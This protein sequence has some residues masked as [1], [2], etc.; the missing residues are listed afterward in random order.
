MDFLDFSIRRIF[1]FRIGLK[2][3]FGSKYLSLTILD[4]VLKIVVEK[5]VYLLNNMPVYHNFK[6]KIFPPK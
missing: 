6:H 2:I 4:P 1:T 5:F 3:G